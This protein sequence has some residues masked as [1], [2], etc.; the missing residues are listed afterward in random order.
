MSIYASNASSTQPSMDATYSLPT[1]YML[2]FHGLKL[3]GSVFL[4]AALLELT[5][6]A[7]VKDVITKTEGGRSL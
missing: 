1:N 6:L 3:G 2:W 5:V 7:T 4:A